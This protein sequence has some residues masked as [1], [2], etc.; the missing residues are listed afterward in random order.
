MILHK[1]MHT[2]FDVLCIGMHCTFSQENKEKVHFPLFFSVLDKA[3]TKQKHSFSRPPFL[4]LSH[5]CITQQ[6][7]NKTIKLFQNVIF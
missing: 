3:K 1:T 2:P 5:R 7:I 4:S 6:S